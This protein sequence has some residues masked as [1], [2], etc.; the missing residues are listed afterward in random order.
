MRLDGLAAL[1]ICCLAAGAACANDTAAE[2]ALGGL[3]FSKSDAISMDSEDLFLSKA[4]VR[5]KYRFTNRTDSPV[6]TLVAFPL[7]DIP[8]AED[9]EGDGA[10]WSDPAD[11][12]K[13]RTSIDDA[14]APLDVLQQAFFNGADISARLKALGV[15][16]N[17]FN[18][19]FSKA[20]N[21]LPQ[22]EREKLLTEKL[23]R[24]DGEALEPLWTSLWTL[25][26]TITR[27]QIFPAQKT[28]VVEHEY[29]PVLGGSV[30]GGLDPKYRRDPDFGFAARQRKFCIDNEWLASFDRKFAARKNRVPPYSEVW[31]GYVLKT[32]ANW[33]GPIADFRLVVDKGAADSLVSFCGNGL[34][35]ISAT[36]FEMRRTNF[37]PT[38]DLNVLIVEYPNGE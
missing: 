17:R 30:G 12:L 23:I 20:I 25:K 22:H 36:Q 28:I 18:E 31:L 2:R 19:T 13:F 24:S 7:P 1:T 16:L 38:G 14:P 29:A 9:G 37:M 15:P 6:E 8:P 32:G 35:K 33:A 34:K 4:V 5:V 10:Y 3:V 27:H 11:G 26:T 21:Q